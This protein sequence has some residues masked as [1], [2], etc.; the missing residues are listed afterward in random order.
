MPVF[1]TADKDKVEDRQPRHDLT[2]K[3]IRFGKEKHCIPVRILLGRR[4]RDR[5]HRIST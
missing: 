1:P 2:N 4:N 5:S 3:I